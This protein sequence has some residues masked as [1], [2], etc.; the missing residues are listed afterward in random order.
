MTARAFGLLTLTL[1]LAGM[2]LLA[3]AWFYSQGAESV[4]ISIERQNNAAGNAS[5][6]A[7]ADYNACVDS[8][9]V[10]DFATGQCRG[11]APRG[12]H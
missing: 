9:R 6:Q 12:R 3:A 4:V 8:G 10:F 11:P 5:D 2:L 1:A 7:R